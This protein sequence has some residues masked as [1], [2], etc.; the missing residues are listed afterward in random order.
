MDA[1]RVEKWVEQHSTATAEWSAKETNEAKEASKLKRPGV[2]TTTQA[3][4]PG[5]GDSEMTPRLGI[6]VAP[7][8]INARE[9][10]QGENGRD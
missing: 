7:G 3:F 8:C 4:E 10:G 5:G 1:G 9:G 6:K 2:D